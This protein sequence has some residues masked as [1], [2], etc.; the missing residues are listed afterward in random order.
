MKVTQHKA[1]VRMD[2]RHALLIVVAL[3]T[4]CRPSLEPLPLTA[5]RFE[6]PAIYSRWW[7]MVEQ[8]SGRAGDFR[9]VEW[10]RVPEPLVQYGGRYVGGFWESRGNRIV[11]AGEFPDDGVMVRHEMLHA[12]LGRGGHPPELFLGSCARVLDCVLC[13]NTKMPAIAFKRVASSALEVTSSAELL[14]PEADGQ[15]WVALRV[16]ARNRLESA[17]LVSDT[18]V[19]SPPPGFLYTLQGPTYGYIGGYPAAHLSQLFFRPGETK[20]WLFEFRVA[21]QPARYRLSP[22]WY[23]LKGGFGRTW[24]AFDSLYV[25]R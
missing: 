14:T 12:I 13:A 4:A 9:R 25:T 19:A 5:Q 3:M 22:G 6:P 21:G 2:P 16:A 15:R 1:Y 11:L 8:C 18:G 20:Q 17:V 7:Q 23:I 24:A 10:F